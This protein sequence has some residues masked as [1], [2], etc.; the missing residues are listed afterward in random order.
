MNGTH[1]A[2][3]KAGNRTGEQIDDIPN[4]GTVNNLNQLTSIG[5][6]GPTRFAGWI[7]EMGAV[8]VAGTPAWMTT[9]T[10]FVG[11][12]NTVLG[13]N[14]VSVIG[15]PVQPILLIDPKRLPIGGFIT[16]GPDGVE[17]GLYLN[18]DFGKFGTVGAGFYWDL[19]RLGNYF[20]PDYW[21]GTMPCE[22]H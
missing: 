3:D 4:Q 15:S 1:Y 16:E 20:N 17:V 8:K 6:A 22:C 13:T 21:K 5:S 18:R 2:Y 12:A 10:N 14:V 11:S 19:N 7:S 9:A